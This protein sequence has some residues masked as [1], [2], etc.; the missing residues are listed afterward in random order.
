MISF[1]KNNL[2]KPNEFANVD[3]NINESIDRSS[4][5]V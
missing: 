5:W 2:I 1:D 4:K 3:R